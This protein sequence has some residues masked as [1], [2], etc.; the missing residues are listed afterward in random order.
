[1]PSRC[2]LGWCHLGFAP[3]TPQSLQDMV[4][5]TTFVCFAF[6]AFGSVPVEGLS[7][8]QSVIVSVLQAFAHLE[9]L[10][11]LQEA[12]TLRLVIGHMFVRQ[13]D[14]SNDLDT[15]RSIHHSAATRCLSTHAHSVQC[16]CQANI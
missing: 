5:L 13:H 3:I 6:V 10:Y 1:M 16:A 12:A 15:F 7:L 4:K 11:P 14:L 9:H 8:P 2:V